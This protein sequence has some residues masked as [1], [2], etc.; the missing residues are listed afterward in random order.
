MCKSW[1]FQKMLHSE[2]LVAKIGLGTA[3]TKHS[4]VRF[5]RSSEK[6]ETFHTRSTA[7]GTDSVHHQRIPIARVIDCATFDGS[8]FLTPSAASKRNQRKVS[9]FIFFRFVISYT[10]IQR[11][12]LISAIVRRLFAEVRQV[13]PLLFQFACFLRIFKIHQKVARFTMSQI[14]VMN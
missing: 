12:F 3:E 7:A 4:D 13:L 6:A 8:L 1:G 10:I 14:N 2:C 9:L 5:G 11:H